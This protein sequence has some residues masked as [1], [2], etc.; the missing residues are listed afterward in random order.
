MFLYNKQSNFIYVKWG[1]TTLESKRVVN[2]IRY[3]LKIYIF[4][5]IGKDQICL[6]FWIFWHQKTPYIL[7]NF[8]PHTCLYICLVYMCWFVIAFLL[9]IY[10]YCIIWINSWNSWNSYKIIWLKESETSKPS[11]LFL[12]LLLIL[13]G[14]FN[15]FRYF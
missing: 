3:W 8:A 10:I 6:Y 9:P 5:F 2:A 7:N 4:I 1:R 11:C 14:T 13:F 15:C 12:L